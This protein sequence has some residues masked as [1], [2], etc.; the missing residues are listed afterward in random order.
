MKI[1]L[2]TS[3]ISAYF[4]MSKPVRQLMTVKWL[5]NEAAEFDL[6][7]STLVIAELSADPDKRRRENML[8]LVRDLSVTVLELQPT[9]VELAASYRRQTIPNEENDSLHI[10]L[11]TVSGIDAIVSWNFRHIVNVKTMK[12]VH[13]INLA[14]HYQSIEIVSI[15]NLGGEKYGSI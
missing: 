11:A 5:Q 10:A 9:A 15:E 13:E 8:N 4:D 2:D 12:A 3:I 7:I 6:Y 14:H 1:Y